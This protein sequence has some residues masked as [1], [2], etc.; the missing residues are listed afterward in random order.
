MRAL[1]AHLVIFHWNRLGLPAGA[2]ATLTRAAARAC[3]PED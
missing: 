2:Q 1:L 3:F